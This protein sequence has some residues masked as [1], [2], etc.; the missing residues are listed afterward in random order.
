MAVV[1]AEA[2]EFAGNRVDDVLLHHGAD[3][4]RAVFLGLDDE[5]PAGLPRQVLAVDG[6]WDTPWMQRL[7]LTESES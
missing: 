7:H 5:V 3:E 4:L 2:R 6:D 1:F